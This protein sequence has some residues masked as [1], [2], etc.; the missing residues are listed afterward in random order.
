MK[1]KALSF[2][3]IVAVAGI[4]FV[5]MLAL[6]LNFFRAQDVSSRIPLLA[7]GLSG[8]LFV[9]AS[10]FA[11]GRSA[12]NYR[13]DFGGNQGDSKS[14]EAALA[15]L[16]HAPLKALVVFFFLSLVYIA[17]L[18]NQGARI[19]LQGGIGLPLFLLSLS[20]GM[21]AAAFVY[22]LSDKLTTTTLLKQD[23]VRYPY[24]LREPRQQTKNL[25]IPTFMSLLS[26]L[27][28]FSVSFLAISRMKADEHGFDSKTF[29]SICALSVFYFMVVISLVVI[30]N[31]NTATLYRSII[32]QFEHLSSSEKDLSK[33]ISIGSVDELGTIA[34][35]MNSFCVGLATNM[36]GLKTA[37]NMLNDLGKNLRES[38]SETESSVTR[39]SV[40]AERVQEKTQYQSASVE[41][42]SSA[43]T[44]I[45]KNIESLDR[46]ISD[47]AASV[48][49]ASASIE[50]MVANITS[51]TLSFKQMA[52]QFSELL[53]SAV[54]GKTVQATAVEKINRIA[55]RSK[56]LLEANKV[57]ATIAAQTNLLAMNAAIEAA[58]AG[59]AGQG[60]SVVADEIRRLAETSSKQSGT[61]KSELAQVQKAIE[62]V[63]T[64]SQES[65]AAFSRVSEQIGST[66]ALVREVQMAMEEQR[67]GSKQILDALRSMNDITSQVK[68]GSQEMSTGNNTVL[69]EISRLQE[70]TLDIKESIEEMTKGTD[71]VAG[72]TKK[73]SAM[74]EGTSVTIRKMDDAIGCFKT[75]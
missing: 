55:E 15:A 56:T 47:Q 44:Q 69:E 14:Y 8:I 64:S 10:S 40:S 5:F 29:I 59:E 25:V 38:V 16:G 41:E 20:W 74:A 73:V 31:T 27:F 24:T 60:F 72:C 23:L 1:D 62:E 70:T 54:E 28:A 49:Q 51:M 58:H 43:V 22:V 50:E 71:G 42:S 34:G 36:A 75:S 63:V 2:R 35:M 4:L 30:W 65:E 66:D 9:V 39:I 21:L 53:T 37:Q 67:E 32:A 61:I 3:V 52:E 26:L 17:V 6:T 46:L 13:Y 33:R 68:L 7:V 57:I 45:A 12:K 18:I 48:T 19:G 11:I